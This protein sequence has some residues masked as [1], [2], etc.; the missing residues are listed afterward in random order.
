MK[1]TPMTSTTLQESGEIN[2]GEELS[3]GEKMFH[4]T[5]HI[6]IV[7]IVALFMSINKELHRG[8]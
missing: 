4:Q 1:V 5:I 3:A 2:G 7:E 8:L 6:V